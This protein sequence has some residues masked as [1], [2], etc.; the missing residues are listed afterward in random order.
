M[1][2]NL[3]A[4]EKYNTVEDKEYDVMIGAPSDDNMPTYMVDWVKNDSD[5]VDS[6]VQWSFNMGSVVTVFHSI[7]NVFWMAKDDQSNAK[8]KAVT[9]DT[10]PLLF[11]FKEVTAPV[12][13]NSRINMVNLLDV[14]LG[15][16]ATSSGTYNYSWN[17]ARSGA[18]ADPNTSK[19]YAWVDK[20]R[21]DSI[22][23]MV[24]IRVSKLSGIANLF[25]DTNN[26]LNT[27]SEVSEEM[28][29]ELFLTLYAA[30][31]G[32]GPKVYACKLQY[33]EEVYSFKIPG[34][35]PTEYRKQQIYYPRVAYALEYGD[36]DLAKAIDKVCG[37]ASYKFS[38]NFGSVLMNL[39]RKTA[40]AH[41]ILLDIKPGN[42]IVFLDADGVTYNN[43]KMIDF[44]PDFTSYAPRQS[45]EDIMFINC[46]MLFFYIGAQEDEASR[47]CF[48]PHMEELKTYVQSRF[49]EFR[50]RDVSEYAIQS[51]Q[52]AIKTQL[53]RTDWEITN[54]ARGLF[55]DNVSFANLMITLH[56]LVNHYGLEQIDIRNLALANDP[57]L[58]NPPLNP[59]QNDQP[60]I[61]QMLTNVLK[62]YANDTR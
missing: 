57:E 61:I 55:D 58:F 40:D 24:T 21:N 12:L 26:N 27:L 4:L 48:Y 8:M 15:A 2:P 25:A 20:V 22:A 3:S 50:S 34:T 29:M 39:M 23:R 47:S 36:S 32:I 41:L 7:G 6:V 59:Y 11:V 49:E 33:I 46:M 17:V 10:D 9:P 30:S 54:G 16:L 44:G 18:E 31:V 1:L 45:V 62:Q 37:I 19:L 38:D 35:K 5:K 28:N 52:R 60:L 42:M 56:R 53:Y 51:L 43:V 14:R 13:P